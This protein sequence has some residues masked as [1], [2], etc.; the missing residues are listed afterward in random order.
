MGQVFAC[1]DCCQAE[2]GEGKAGWVG[3]GRCQRAR[4][5]SLSTLYCILTERLKE[6]GFD[7]QIE[8]VIK[9]FLLRTIRNKI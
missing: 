9:K 5:A 7:G 2:Y 3:M 1:S 4:D 6:W 8:C